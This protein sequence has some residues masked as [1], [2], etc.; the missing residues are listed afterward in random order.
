MT[1]GVRVVE[2]LDEREPLAD[3]AL[4]LIT[5]MFAPADRQ[6]LAELRSE[7]AERRLGMT[8]GSYLHLLAAVEEGSTE[9]AGIIVGVYLDRVNAGFI[10]YL[11]VRH[12]FR[13]QRI[14]RVLRPRLIETFTEDARREG[15]EDVAWILGE[16]RRESP[17]LRRLV[18]T[19]G[20]IPFDLR[21]YHPGMSLDGGE[22]YVLYRQPVSDMRRELP[23]ALVRRILYAIYRRAYRVRYPL[24]RDI[25]AD[26]LRQLECRSTVGVHPAFLDTLEGRGS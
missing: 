13:G 3:A 6:P 19:R 10:S 15:R 7:L 14:A 20:A 26:M 1:D 4:A 16:V 12:N 2:I 25:F 24:Q 8:S 18:R 22:E 11:A 5:D 23:V 17:W 9:P 21:Y